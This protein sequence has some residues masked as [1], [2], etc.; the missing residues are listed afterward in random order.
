MNILINLNR[1]NRIAFESD[2]LKM[3]V[4]SYDADHDDK[5]TYSDFINMIVT[6]KDPILK[7]L[8][9]K[10]SKSSMLKEAEN[11]LNSK[12]AEQVEANLIKF[13]LKEMELF[14]NLNN[15]IKEIRNDYNE[16]TFISN[17]FSQ[18]D[19]ENQNYFR[20][21]QYSNLF[22]FKRFFFNI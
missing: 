16:I 5:L 6:S 20:E 12:L 9:I 13:F 18:L 3:I 14:R 17:L 21:E 11:K 1:R 8:A 15:F 2:Q 7:Q 4:S 19:L 22:I 10:F